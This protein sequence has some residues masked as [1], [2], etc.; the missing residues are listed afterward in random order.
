MHFRHLTRGSRSTPEVSR[1]L[2]GGA[3]HRKCPNKQ[4]P[5]QRRIAARAHFRRPCRGARRCCVVFRWLAPPANIQCPSGTVPLLPVTVQVS[6]H[7]RGE[8][9]MTR[10]RLVPEFPR[11]CR[12][13]HRAGE[14]PRSGCMM[15]APCFSA[16]T[17]A[18]K[19]SCRVA[20]A[21]LREKIGL[22]KL[23]PMTLE[24]GSEFLCVA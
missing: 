19:A 2:A 23:D 3:S 1:K 13:V 21:D 18:R 12:G 15:V 11:D 17:P 8:K 9:W 4:P 14:L 5:R 16:G 24:K 20:T 10:C 22:I 7:N 6:D